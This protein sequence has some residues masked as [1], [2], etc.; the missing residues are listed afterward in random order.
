MRKHCLLA[1]SALFTCAL[2]SVPLT[3][4]ANSDKRTLYQL[5]KDPKAAVIVLDYKGGFRPPRT[6]HKP[7]MTIQAD[8]TVLVPARFAGQKS[9]RGKISS[10]ELHNLLDFI[11]FKNQFLKYDKKTVE[12]KLR[13]VPGPRLRIADAATVVIRVDIP[14]M[15]NEASRYALGMGK[16]RQVKELRQLVAV[17]HRLQQVSTFVRLGGKKAVAK[18]LKLVNAE[19]KAKYPKVKPLTTADLQ[20]G[21][22]RADGSVVYVSFFRRKTAANGKP[23]P[24]AAYTSGTVNK[25]AGK[26]VKVFVSH[27]IPGVRRVRGKGKPQDL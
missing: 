21:G 14:G 27:R 13:K 20:S 1:L 2:C 12:A 26:P 22:V 24:G 9:F 8:G 23:V 25:P 15:K 3:T 17:H 6:S 19:L 5:P 10:T 16:D 11:I 7:A 4:R 18:W